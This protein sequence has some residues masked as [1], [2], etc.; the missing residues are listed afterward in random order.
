MPTYSIQK[1][2]EIATSIDHV[3]SAV[4]D[5]NTWSIWSPWLLAE[6]D[7]A[8]RVAEDGRSYSWSGKIV[9]SGRMEVLEETPRQTISYKLTF[10]TPWKSTSTVDFLFQSKGQSTEAT[11]TM[12]GSLPFFLFWMKKMMTAFVGMDYQR[13]LLMLKDYCETGSVPSK[14]KFPGRMSFQG[15][16]YLG[17]KS[18]CFIDDI[19]PR[20]KIDFEKLNTAIESSKI[21]PSGNPFCIYHKYDAISQK[22]EYTVGIP[23]SSLPRKVPS[24]LHS[25][26]IQ[27]CEAYH[28]S[29]H[30]PYRHLGNGWSAGMMRSRSKVFKQ[31]KAIPPFEIYENDPNAVAENDL[32][33]SIYFPVK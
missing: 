10:L 24:A 30:G 16:S 26:S 27:S 2:I 14:L 21:N 20:M 31:N 4:K 23:V 29:H 22:T 32:R 7:C 33:T 8:I 6:P 11:W 5:F 28:I 15:F 9:G 19:G 25:G 3:Y 13:G 12:N 18:N 1:S 17:I